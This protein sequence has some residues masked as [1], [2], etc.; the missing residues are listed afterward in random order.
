MPDLN[1]FIG[2]KPTQKSISN[3]EKIVG[4]KPCFKCDLDANEYYWNPVDFIMTWTCS[5]GHINNVKVN[6]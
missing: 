2:P 5:A 4:S 1:E 6:S 3:L